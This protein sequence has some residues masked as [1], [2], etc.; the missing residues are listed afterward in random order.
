MSPLIP[1]ALPLLKPPSCPFA[2]YLS[3]LHSPY[4]LFVFSSSALDLLLLMS[5]NFMFSYKIGWIGFF[6]LKGYI[7]PFLS[8]TLLFS[9]FSVFFPHI[10]PPPPLCSGS[11]FQLATTQKTNCTLGAWVPF[12]VSGSQ[13]ERHIWHAFLPSC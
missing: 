2:A 13:C 6:F 3:S 8:L 5:Y 7:S 10:P 4:C 11:S 1:S 9:S 12:C